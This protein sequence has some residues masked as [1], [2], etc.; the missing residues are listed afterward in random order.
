MIEDAFTFQCDTP[1]YSRKNDP[2]KW[3]KTTETNG[4]MYHGYPAFE[5]IP[6]DSNINTVIRLGDFVIDIDTE[7]IACLDAIKILG[8]FESTFSI[9]PDQWRV[10]LSGKKGVHLELPAKVLGVE[11]GHTWLTLGFKRLAIEIEAALG[12]NIDTSMYNKGTGKPYRQPNVMRD[13]GTCKRQI[14]PEDLYSIID[15]EDYVSACNEIGEVWDVENPVLNVQLKELMV[16]YLF[17]ATDNQR[18]AESRIYMTDEEQEALAAKVPECI[19]HLSSL[20]SYTASGCTF[21]DIAIQVTAYAISAKI[22]ESDFLAGCDTFISEYPST[23]LKSKKQRVE[24]CVARYR[25]MKANDNQHSCGGVLA[26]KTGYFDCKNCRNFRLPDAPALSTIKIFD[27]KGEMPDNYTLQIPDTILRDGGL[28]QLGIEALAA[29]G[30]PNIPQYSMASVSAFLARAISGKISLQDIWPNLFNIKIGTSSTGKS[31]VDKFLCQSIDNT[32]VQ[33]FVGSTDI[34]SGP[35]IFTSLKEQPQTIIIL[36]EVTKVFRGTGSGGDSVTEGIKDALMELYS[37]SGQTLEKKYANSKNHIKI[38]NPCL[39]FCGNATEVVLDVIQE[40]DFRTG[41]MTRMDFFVYDGQIPY[42]SIMQGENKK[43]IEFGEKLRILH[44]LGMNSGI[45]HAL[46]LTKNAVSTL[47]TISRDIIDRQNIAEQILKPIIG[48]SYQRIVKYA[49]L[50][51]ASQVGMH[52]G[53]LNDLQA[54]MTTKELL[55]GK[56][57]ADMLTE[58]KT[59]TLRDNVVSGDF[60]QDRERFKKAIAQCC[61]HKVRPTFAIMANKQRKMKDWKPAYSKEIISVLVKSG[62]I[63]TDDSKSVTG[64]YLT[65]QDD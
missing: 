44:E 51:R 3:I 62:E 53:G 21:N 35:A 25:T 37:K 43:L 48:R 61:K 5:M 64:Y 65:K 59:T 24:N 18:R 40:Q 4:K 52:G 14:E 63:L 20:T 8:W 60:H 46:Q 39:T 13:I 16:G 45:P 56:D 10:Y 41:L 12:I 2:S 19:R 15:N 42:R 38:D 23:S 1:N 9:E 7:E 29:P 57:V 31:D 27:T 17:E 58:W 22:P 34:A 32:G 50:A 11:Q 26:L 6:I 55:W 36:D 28:L 33:G 49:L 47:T 54:P 30:F